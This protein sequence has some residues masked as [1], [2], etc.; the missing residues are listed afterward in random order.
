[1]REFFFSPSLFVVAEVIDKQIQSEIS[2][3]PFKT[4]SK[5]VALQKLTNS[6][7]SLQKFQVELPGANFQT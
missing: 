5:L 4:Y 7:K 3:P 6:E 2:R 1:M